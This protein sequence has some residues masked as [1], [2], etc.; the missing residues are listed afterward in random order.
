MTLRT[1]RYL[2]QVER[3]PQ[4]GG[5]ILAQ[6]D[7]DSVVVYQAFRSESPPGVCA[8]FQSIILARQRPDI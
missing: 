5:V 7:D 8:L 1:E 6:F 3:W 2:D 4:R